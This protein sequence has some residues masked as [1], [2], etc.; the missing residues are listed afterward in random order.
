MLVYHGDRVLEVI[1]NRVLCDI[2]WPTGSCSRWPM[3]PGLP[4]C[5][6]HTPSSQDE[7]HLCSQPSSQAVRLTSRLCKKANGNQAGRLLNSPGSSF[8]P[9][10]AAKNSIH[11]NRSVSP[12][13]DKGLSRLVISRS[14]K[15][16]RHLLGNI[17]RSK[18]KTC[19]CRSQPH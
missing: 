19:L 3:G 16:G 18:T 12:S 15:R 13:E 11:L 2:G 17:M 1:I 7:L 5:P 14:I 9:P 8:P 10:D 6:D 4:C